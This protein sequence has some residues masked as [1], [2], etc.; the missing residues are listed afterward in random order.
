MSTPP[1]VSSIL[2]SAF[3]LEGQAYLINCVRKWE[4]A[5]RLDETSFNLTVEGIALMLVMGDKDCNVTMQEF[6]G[7]SRMC[8]GGRHSEIPQI[9]S[10]RIK[11]CNIVRA[12]ASMLEIKD[13]MPLSTRMT[14]ISACISLVSSEILVIDSYTSE[15]GYIMATMM[16]HYN[17]IENRADVTVHH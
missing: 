2:K 4:H 11:E 1:I 6:Q 10:E 13:A 16:S 7:K 17:E 14:L 8:I 5:H 15:F 12:V 9:D 3:T